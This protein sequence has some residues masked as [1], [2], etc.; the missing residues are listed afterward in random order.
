MKFWDSS[1]LVPLLVDQ[2]TSG[3]LEGLFRY[4]AD[5]AVWWATPVEC[6]S[7]LAR[8]PREKKFSSSDVQ[9]AYGLLD[10]LLRGAYEVQ[11]DDEIRK[12]AQCL[13]TK[14][15][16]RAADSLQ[17]AAALFWCEE[18]PR[19]MAFVCLDNRLSLAAVLEGFRVEPWSGEVHERPYDPDFD[20]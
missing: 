4:D 19:G 18:Q 2:A 7:A 10:L 16:L 13:V 15:N 14:H 9:R 3:S 20:D 12:M 5:I 11:P 8:A 1:A 6:A 17:L